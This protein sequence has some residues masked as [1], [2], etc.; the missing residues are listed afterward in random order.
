[1]P[2]FK[3]MKFRTEDGKHCRKIRLKLAELGY[4]NLSPSGAALYDG[5]GYLFTCTSGS[6]VWTRDSELKDA[7]EYTLEQLIE[8]TKMSKLNAKPKSPDD[9]VAIEF[10]G[11]ELACLRA[12]MYRVSG[13]TGFDL[14]ARLGELFDCPNYYDKFNKMMERVIH[15]HRDYNSYED[16]NLAILFNTKQ[17]E[18]E[19]KR[20]EL[21]KQIDY[22]KQLEQELTELEQR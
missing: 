17:K 11:K 10:T 3:A 16:L 12:I 5:T 22:V 14:R 1:M 7:Q 6:V 15:N 19:A 18:V 20:E 2:Q 13:S 8:E 4:I 9:T 21:R